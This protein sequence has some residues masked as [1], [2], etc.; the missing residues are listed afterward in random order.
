MAREE[1][2]VA[3]I[4]ELSWKPFRKSKSSATPMV[5]SK[6]GFKEPPRPVML[7]G[8]KFYPIYLSLA[9]RGRGKELLLW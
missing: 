8:I 6:R 2:M 3:T 9:N 4:L 1:I 5:T 7:K